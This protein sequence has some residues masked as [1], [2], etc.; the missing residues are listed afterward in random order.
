ML[1]TARRSIDV[2]GLPEEAVRAVESLVSLLR[3]EPQTV[4]P[5]YPSPEEWVKAIREWAESHQPLGSS[6][7]YS[8]ESIYGVRGE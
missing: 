5:P 2:S 1:P 8:R 7:D 3:R 6:A 4:P